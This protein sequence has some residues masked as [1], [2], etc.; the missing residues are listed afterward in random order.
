[1]VFK[2][3]NNTV[4]YKDWQPAVYKWMHVFSLTHTYTPKV[5][6]DPI[7]KSPNIFTYG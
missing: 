5:T 2:H 3:K 4:Y 7:L 1:M 6:K